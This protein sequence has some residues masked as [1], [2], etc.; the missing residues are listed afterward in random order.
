MQ[1]KVKKEEDDEEAMEEAVDTVAKEFRGLHDAKRAA[2]AH[3]QPT[4]TTTTAP[5]ITTTG[6]ARK[7]KRNILV[8]PNQGPEGDGDEEALNA[9][10]SSEIK[11]DRKLDYP[12]GKSR[13]YTGKR[14]AKG[15]QYPEPHSIASMKARLG[16]GRMIRKPRAKAMVDELALVGSSFCKELMY[17]LGKHQVKDRASN[18]AGW[19]VALR[20][21]ARDST[22]LQKGVRDILTRYTGANIE[23]DKE[24]WDQERRWMW[25]AYEYVC[26]QMVSNE[27]DSFRKGTRMMEDFIAENG[28]EYFMDPDNHTHPLPID[29]DPATGLPFA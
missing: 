18:S 7:V 8:N 3:A 9:I 20:E 13:S 26:M 25:H 28:N 4:P 24:F 23:P 1:I 6:R 11:Y 14:K 5:T 10:V 22:I 27:Q 19:R 17:V 21:L 29:L 15:G 2:S 12:R 16:I